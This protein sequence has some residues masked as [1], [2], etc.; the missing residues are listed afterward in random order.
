MRLPALPGV[1]TT[2]EVGLPD[3]VILGN[4][5]GIA[6]PR[7]L[8][9]SIANRISAAVRAVLGE[10]EVRKRYAEIGANPVANSPAEFGDR[11]RSEASG[12]EAIINKTGAKPD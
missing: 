10:P 6:G 1:P 4:W 2:K 9:T 12:W 5:W 7:G 3:G 8:D 11:M